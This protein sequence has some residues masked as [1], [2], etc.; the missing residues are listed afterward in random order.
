MRRRAGL[1]AFAA[2]LHARQRIGLAV[3]GRISVA[4]G[5]AGRARTRYAA[6]TTT[7]EAYPRRGAGQAAAAAVLP[8]ALNVSF[9]TIAGIAVTICVAGRTRAGIRG[10]TRVAATWARAAVA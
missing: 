6:T 3:I 1:A 10:G 7:R 5:V 9:A 8:V 4:V 2:A